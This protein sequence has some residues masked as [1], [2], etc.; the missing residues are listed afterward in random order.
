MQVLPISY[1]IFIWN[2]DLGLPFLMGEVWYID[3]SDIYAWWLIGL[4][5]R[6]SITF[7]C[8]LPTQKDSVLGKCQRLQRPD[9]VLSRESSLSMPFP[10]RCKS[11]LC[12]SLLAARAAPEA[13]CT[14]AVI[15]A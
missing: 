1:S 4:Y 15:D 3:M 6:S 12:S 7:C 10:F 9:P 13:R 8:V 5:V 11:Q 2:G 14:R